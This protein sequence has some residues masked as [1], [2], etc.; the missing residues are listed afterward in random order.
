[1]R[2]PARRPA[3]KELQHVMPTLKRLAVTLG[4]AGVLA[5]GG[6]VAGAHATMAA[7]LPMRTDVVS[8]AL[9]PFDY[10]TGA[11][12]EACARHTA[13]GQ[14]TTGTTEPQVCIGSGLSFIGPAVG[15]VATVIGPTT[16]GPAQVN[17]NVS[18]GNIAG[19]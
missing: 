1:M 7:S 5:I 14:G 6:S 19:V 17:S 4:V 10:P 8:P 16:I 2:W 15:Q 11:A 18:A 9:L 12:A 3:E 13:T